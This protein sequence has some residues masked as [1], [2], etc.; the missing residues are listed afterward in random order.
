MK[1]DEN[2]GIGESV[3]ADLRA[4]ILLDH[5]VAAQERGG[6]LEVRIFV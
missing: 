3:A 5:K 1:A 4:A 6:H 2:G